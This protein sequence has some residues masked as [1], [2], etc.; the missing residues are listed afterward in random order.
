MNNCFHLILVMI[1]T[2][3]N[4]RHFAECGSPSHWEAGA[5][6]T[7]T[8]SLLVLFTAVESFG[9]FFIFI[10]FAAVAGV[11]AAVVEVIVAEEVFMT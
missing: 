4:V 10:F 2:W 1:M 8:V 11:A 9:F 3:I 6:F 7:W 5:Y